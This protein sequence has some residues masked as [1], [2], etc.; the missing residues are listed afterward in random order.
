MYQYRRCNFPSL[1]IEDFSQKEEVTNLFVFYFYEE[2]IHAAVR[3]PKS[4]HDTKF[5]AVSR[6]N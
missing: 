5:D 3:Y 4:W 6:L 1:Y 2:L